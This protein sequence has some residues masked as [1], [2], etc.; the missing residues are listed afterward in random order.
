MATPNFEYEVNLLAQGYTRIAGVDEA[1]V[2]PLAGPIVAAA[3]I[4]DPTKVSTLVSARVTDSKKLSPER[5]EKLYSLII[6]S[7]LEYAVS[8]VYPPEI[9]TLKNVQKCGFLARFRAISQIHP[10]FIVCDHFEVPEVLVPSVGITKG[11]SLVLSIGAAS[12]LA[13]VTRDRYM[14]QLAQQF[15]QYQFEINKGYWSEDHIAAIGKYGITEHHK[16]YYHPIPEILAR[17]NAQATP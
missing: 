10:D 3:V 8:F 13:K 4:L 11:D 2:G 12:I 17:R 9:N 15:P 5:R 14:V 6:D 7:C 1:G 16:S